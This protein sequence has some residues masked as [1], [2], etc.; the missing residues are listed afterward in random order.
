MTTTGTLYIVSAP[1]GAGKTSLVK[2]LIDTMAQVRVSVSHTTRA[3]RPGEV[4]GVNYH[5][6]ARED[7]VEMLKQGDFLEHAEVFGNLYGTSHSW[8]KQTLAKGYDLILEID[9]QGAQQVRKLVPDAKSIFILPPTHKDLRQR[10]HNRGQDADD[11]IDLRMQ[12]AIAEMSHYVEYDYI[13]INDQFATALDD[14]K[15][16]FRA[17]QLRLE[18]QQKR[19]TQLLCDLLR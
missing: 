3:M 9:W 12:Q 8:V 7:F 15:A 6:T 13:V 11:V 1:S 4:D 19:H 14:L 17:N 16:I 18:S 5:F 2:A 10:L